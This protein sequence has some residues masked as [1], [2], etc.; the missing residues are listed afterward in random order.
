VTTAS[1]PCLGENHGGAAYWRQWRPVGETTLIAGS[2][3]YERHLRVPAGW[4]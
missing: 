3:R 2:N 1:V 4:L